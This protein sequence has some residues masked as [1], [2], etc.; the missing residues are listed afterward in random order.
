M[1]RAAAAAP[2][3]QDWKIQTFDTMVKGDRQTLAAL[4]HAQ[5]EV[6]RQLNALSFSNKTS[7]SP[8]RA[9]LE[10]AKRNIQRSMAELYRKL[11]DI[12]R[13]RR[14]EAA[15]RLIDV[16]AQLDVFLLSRAG[17]G[18]ADEF[19]QSF[20]TSMKLTAESG[21]D[22][23]NQRVTGGSYNT[24]SERVYRSSTVVG[25]QVDKLVNSALAQALSAKEFASSVREFI[26]PSTPG[27]ARYAS[28]RL[29]RTEINNA[30]HALAV[31][32]VQEKPWV[33]G[34]RWQLSGSHP[35]TDIC[36]TIA[37]G[38][39]KGDG[40]YPKSG[41]PAKPHP[42]CFCYVTPEVQNEEDFLNSLVGGE[43]DD[44]LGRFVGGPTRL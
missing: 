1:A 14:L 22:R 42:Q 43:Y 27:G 23:M 28:L 4:R 38:G 18:F 8:R 36:N 32:Q 7:A 37:S 3:P 40:V 33:T 25:A 20:A 12:T 13:A 17:Y 16:Q 44:Y 6:S 11:G 19:G 35:R 34:L 5:L 24:L 10:F 29:A 26:N 39:P 21:L 41:T 15:S 9:Q 31:F 2:R 30:A